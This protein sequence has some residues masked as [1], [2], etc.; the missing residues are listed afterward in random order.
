MHIS[1]VCLLIF[2]NA[3][4]VMSFPMTMSSEAILAKELYA[5]C[6]NL[7]CWSSAVMGVFLETAARATAVVNSDPLIRVGSCLTTGT[8]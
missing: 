1:Q 8:R 7:M 4:E 5:R 3:D 2:L 6:P